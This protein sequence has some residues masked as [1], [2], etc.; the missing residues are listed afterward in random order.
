MFKTISEFTVE[1]TKESENTMKIIA[2][3]TDESLGKYV[4][5]GHRTIG[6]V[7]WHIIQC[8]PEMSGHTGLEVV[9][10]CEKTPVPKSA[11][12]IRE[13]YNM[14]ATSLIKEIEE[15]WT[16]ES[17]EVEDNLY[18]EMW[19]RGLTLNILLKHEIHHRGQLTV[20]MREAG[21]KVPGVYGPSKEEWGNFGAPVPEI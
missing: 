21:L 12:E 2:A 16:D 17:L 19:K 20:L 4:T 14:A 3:L 10:P 7:I 13:A 11:D 1:W 8:I 18:G 5:D 15:K 6:R 9:G